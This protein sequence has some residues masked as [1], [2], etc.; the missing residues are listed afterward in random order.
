MRKAITFTLALLIAGSTFAAGEIWRWKDANGVWHYSD[1]RPSQAGAELVSRS[2]RPTT[3]QAVASPAPP[4][5]PSTPTLA[6]GGPPPV[7]ED[8]ASQVRQ[9][10][11]AAKAEQCKTAEEAYQQVVRARRILKADG[12]TYMNNAEIDAERLKVRSLRDQ[13]CGPGA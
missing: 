1:Q 4:P 11:A 7:S 6:D 13:A 5:P 10:A 8:V 9:E 2:G 3:G 12:V